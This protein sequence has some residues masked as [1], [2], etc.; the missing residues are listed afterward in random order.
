MGTP[1][2]KSSTDKIR[3]MPSAF[4]AKVRPQPRRTGP[5]WFV[6]GFLGGLAALFF[7]DSR[8]GAARRQMVVDKITSR[9]NEMM[10]LSGRKARHLRDRAMGAVA[11]E[12]SDIDAA[13]V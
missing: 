13:E 1:D 10:E 5:L 11:A 3:D 8:R 4:I 6:A 7:F 12:R 9:G 2:L